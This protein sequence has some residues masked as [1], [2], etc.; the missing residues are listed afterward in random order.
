MRYFVLAFLLILTVIMIAVAA[1]A[2]SEAHAQSD[3]VQVAEAQVI[4]ELRDPGSARIAT[5]G[6]LHGARNARGEPVD[7]V[8]GRLSAVNG[9]GGRSADSAFVVDLTHGSAYLTDPSIAANPYKAKIGG[10][11]FTHL[12]LGM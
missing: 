4:Q 12:C 5:A 8:C 3:P 7:V 6:F 1:V 9:F 10:L 11:V 2:A